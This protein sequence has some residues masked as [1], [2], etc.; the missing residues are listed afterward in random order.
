MNSTPGIAALAERLDDAGVVCVGSG[1]PVAGKL[2]AR[3]YRTLVINAAQSEP[4]MHKDW[5][6]LAHFS[7]CVFDGAAVLAEALGI[8]RTFLAAREEFL[9]VLPECTA[10]ARQRRVAICRLPDIYPLGYEAILKREILRLPLGTVNDDVLVVNAETLRNIAWA[11]LRS[12]PVTDKIIT[13]AGAVAQPLSLRVPIGTSFGDCL[14]LAGGVKG[15]AFVVFKNG[16]LGG[17]R[18][19]PAQAWAKRWNR[20]ARIAVRHVTVIVWSSARM[21]MCVPTAIVW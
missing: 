16:V 18:V 21:R 20:S 11:V 2:G 17:A 9:A 14:A 7:A 6:L 8:T 13:V 1:F 3:P 10:L 19:D 5:A 12:R 15:E 4:L